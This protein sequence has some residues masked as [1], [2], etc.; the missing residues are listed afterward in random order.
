M[1]DLLVV[2]DE[3]ALG[4]FV[5]RSL[6]R[7]GLPHRLAQN[8][9][10]A[11]SL[12]D[13]RWPGAVLLDLTLPGE[14]DGWGVWDRLRAKSTHEPLRVVVFAAELDTSDEF[15]ARRRGAWAILR[16]P[17]ARARLVEVLRDALAEGANG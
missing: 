15:E 2:E 9:Q 7:A 3:F 8:G 12:A 17:V 4:E 6:E 5:R 1:P 16:K 14:L 13:E 10:Q 11:L